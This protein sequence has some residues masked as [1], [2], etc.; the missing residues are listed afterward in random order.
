MKQ[1]PHRLGL[2]PDAVGE[3]VLGDLP[4]HAGRQGNALS[5]WRVVRFFAHASLYTAM[6]RVV[7]VVKIGVDYGKAVVHKGCTNTGGTDGQD[8]S[9]N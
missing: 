1:L 4:P 8:R 2:G 5:D 3:A 6:V 7:Q 9:G